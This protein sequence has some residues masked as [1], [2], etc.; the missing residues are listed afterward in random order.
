MEAA[1]TNG[2]EIDGNKEDLEAAMEDF[3]MKQTE[4]ESGT[5]ATPAVRLRFQ[6]AWCARECLLHT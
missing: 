2:S 6:P 5:L 1:S 4:R 3:L